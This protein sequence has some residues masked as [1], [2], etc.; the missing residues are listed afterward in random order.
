MNI[1][2]SDDP[3]YRYKMPIPN[4][5]HIGRGNGKITNLENIK[6][7]SLSINIPIKILLQY[8]CFILGTNFK[9]NPEIGYCING[10]YTKKELIDLIIKFN[11]FF[12][13]C[14]KCGIPELSPTIQGKKK[15][16]QLLYSCSACGEDYI[17]ESNNKINN[18][19]IDNLIKYYENNEFIK[20][21]GNI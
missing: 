12:V 7:I 8:I 4:I 14:N 3:F 15:N 5:K 16:K 6:E 18:K 20:T 2:N 9:N 19:I 11:K 13:I 1:N 21:N 10:H 17:L